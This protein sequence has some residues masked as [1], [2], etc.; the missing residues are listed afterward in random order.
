M[1]SPGISTSNFS[2]ACAEMCINLM[3]SSNPKGVTEPSITSCEIEMIPIRL[4]EENNRPTVL[5]KR[6]VSR[7]DLTG[8]LDQNSISESIK[9]LVKGSLQELRMLDLKFPAQKKSAIFYCKISF[10]NGEKHLNSLHQYMLTKTTVLKEPPT[11]ELVLKFVNGVR[12]SY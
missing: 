9:E 10:Y 1:A 11:A 8:V 6:K 3:N 7:L 12:N 2:V 4:A 5:G